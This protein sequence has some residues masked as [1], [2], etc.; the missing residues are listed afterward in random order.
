MDDWQPILNSI[1]YN[2]NINNLF[3]LRNICHE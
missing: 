3:Y 2:K 1:H